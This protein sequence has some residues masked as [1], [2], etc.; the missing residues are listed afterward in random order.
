MLKMLD[1][2]SGIGGFSLAASWT[3]GIETVAFCEIEPYCQKVLKK[4]WLD[5]PIFPDIKELRGEDIGS[6]DII[7][8]GPPCQPASCAGK[9]RG[10]KDDRWLWPEAIQLVREI[11]PRWCVFENPTG[12]L[13]LDGG[14]AFEDL[15]SQLESEG[16]EVQA[17]VIPACGV[18]APHRRNR[19]WIVANSERRG[20][21]ENRKR[22]SMERISGDGPN[23][24]MPIK[25]PS[26]NVGNA[27][28]SGCNRKSRRGSE[29]K[30]TH[31]HSKL[32]KVINPD[33]GR[34]RL[35]TG[36]CGKQTGREIISGYG[37]VANADGERLQIAE[38]ERQHGR[39]AAQCCRRAIESSVGRVAD[40]L[41]SELDGHWNVEPDIPRVA[42]GVKSRVD[43]LRGLGNAIVPQ[44][45][46]PILQAIVDIET[47]LIEGR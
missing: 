8:G 31:R 4:H 12:I 34:Q 43:R 16:Y 19:V 17:V 6:V 2:F 45:A 37:L 15:L 40:G 13:T 26:A 3:G 21:G 14:M 42:T 23:D 11:H 9:R 20:C 27:E 39:S 41:S 46:Y 5:V 35:Q 18:G 24:S 28:R 10:A 47:G 32:E 44:V 33:T 22:R 25:E 30:F 38:Q 7:C 29:Q 36:G 1:L